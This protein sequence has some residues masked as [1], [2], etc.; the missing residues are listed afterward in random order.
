MLNYRQ[1]RLDERAILPKTGLSYKADDQGTNSRI[2]VMIAE[3]LAF[4]R[5]TSHA[6]PTSGASIEDFARWLL[7]T[8]NSNLTDTLIC[9]VYIKR[10]SDHLSPACRVTHETPYRILV[11]ALLLA[12]KF[13]D[14]TP[15]ENV[16]WCSLLSPWLS[17]SD[18]ATMERQFLH[19]IAYQL[20]VTSVDFKAFTIKL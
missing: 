17:L 4:G 20:T 13:N 11:T 19:R 8:T 10:F 14:D 6:P 2:I 7:M 16:A 18:L 5:I 15:Q 12:R 3:A 9:L 1:Y